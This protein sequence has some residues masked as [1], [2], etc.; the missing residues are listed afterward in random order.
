V[1]RRV[2]F[3]LI[4]IVFAGASLPAQTF[5]L[6]TGRE[7]VTSLDG[8]WRFHTGDNPAWASPSFDDSD[9]P[10]IRSDES[11]T[12]QG[13]RDYAGY[14]WYRFKIQVPDGSRPPDLLLPAVFTGYQLYANG[15]L[16]GG[17]GSIVPTRNPVF[18]L[19][20]QVY[21]LPPG[22]EGPQFIQIAI[23]VWYVAGLGY[24]GGMLEP[25]S[26]VGAPA[27]LARELSRDQ[28]ERNCACRKRIRILPACLARRPY[29]SGPVFLA[30]RRSRIFVVLRPSSRRG[31]RSGTCPRWDL[32]DDSNDSLSCH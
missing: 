16:I 15:R 13:Y 5:S 6:V 11:W 3:G 2:L 20:P 32:C 26:V 29:H 4:F 31:R 17:E 28:D 8:L 14:A 30:P 10:L 18:A 1:K 22:V 9:W 24:H 27:V 25:G 23:R 7:P 21:D 19:V 12:A